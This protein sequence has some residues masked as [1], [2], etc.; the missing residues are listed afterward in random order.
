MVS[1]VF[2]TFEGPE[3]SGKSTQ[4]G[5]LTDRLREDGVSVTAVREPGGTPIGDIIRGIVQYD[6]AGGPV[7][8]ETET[9]LFAASRAQLVGTV[10]APALARGDWVV[11]DRFADS[12]TAYQGYGRGFDI[13]RILMLNA[14]ATGGVTPDL[15]ILLDL[16]LDVGFER[17]RSRQSDSSTTHD[18]IENESKGFHRAVRTGYLKMAER[19]PQRFRI[20]DASGSVDDVHSV[21]WQHVKDLTESHGK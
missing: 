19:W 4:A 3:G 10:I 5:M 2:I 14:F 16:D 11:C 21:I 20:V 17:V 12:T 15:T 7:F 13:D 9:L 1:G 18:R 6:T 8:P